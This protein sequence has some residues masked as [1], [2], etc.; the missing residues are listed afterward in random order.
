[1]T[2]P[3]IENEVILA[4]AGTGKTHALTSRILRLLALEVRPD[5]L[6]ALTFTRKAAGEFAN[7]VFRRLARAAREPDAAAQLAAD[8]ELDGWTPAR[9]A[10]LLARIVH[11]MERLQFRTFD[12]F[13]QRVVS[14]MPFELGLPGGVQML[15]ESEA[16]ELRDR[17][18]TRLLA[19]DHDPAAQDALLAAYR[20]ATWGA[21]EKGLRRK[22]E[23]FI[24]TSHAHFLESREACQWGDIAGIWPDGC[25]WLEESEDIREDALTLE[26]WAREK[27]GEVYRS[28]EKFAVEAAK[29]EPGMRLPTGR[30]GE[31]ILE[32]FAADPRS[33]AL[34]LT[35]RRKEVLIDE[36]M[37]LPL[38]RIVGRLV[39]GSLRRHLRV[40]TGI[41]RVLEPFD[42][43]YHE[44][45]RL[46]GR[47][48]FA[49][50]VE[51]LRRVPALEWQARL[52]ARVDHWLFDEFQDTSLQQWQVVEN[53]VDEV[54]QDASGRR[55]AFFVGDP[56]Q[57]IYRWRGGEHRLLERI[58]AHYGGRFRER[59]LVKS[60]RSDP[61]VIELVNRYGAVAADPANGL[62]AEVVAEWQRFWLAHESAA[63][64]RQGHA[65]MQLLENE[66][67]LPDRVLAALE[68]IDPIGRGLS[69]A[70]LTRN[71]TAARELA[72]G[73]RER[74]FLRVAAETDEQIAID[75]PV[76]RGLLALIAAVTHPADSASR[77]AVA[78]SPLGALL[79]E[80]GWSALA[81]W[82]F[83]RVTAAGL[84]ATL[85]AVI[86]RLPQGAPTD[87]FSRQRLRL[88]FEL[89][90]TH[91]ATGRDGLDGFLRLAASH[92]R[93]ETASSGNVQILTIHR[94]KGLGF[95]VV[96]LPVFDT[97]RMDGAPTDAFLAWR[98][99]RLATEWLL[100]RPTSVVAGM[101]AV[102]A[103]AHEQQRRDAA[104]DELCVWYVGLTRARHALHVFTL[105]PGK[106]GGTSPVVLLHRA[107][108]SVESAPEGLLWTAGDADWFRAI[109]D[110]K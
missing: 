100:H 94:S 11:E 19:A 103:R 101:D 66:E 13:F 5:A 31:Q 9:F 108:A 104:Y 41:R 99:E 105:A 29:W 55:S 93:R 37:V 109:G 67:E 53:L 102:L 79:D 96:I 1:M 34:T 16:A 4:S 64:E 25:A 44:E 46:S 110:Q 18:L 60:Y 62:P 7:T 106:S 39:C 95:D 22:L 14:A 20:E 77:H 54:V 87:A 71:N 50:V 30:V 80:G 90:R 63:P 49:D 58:L 82:F 23:G 92:A 74:G 32:Q 56:K 51:M 84:E 3:L 12:A 91:D 28:L 69:C 21:E 45:V 35:Y 97:T 98:G 86:D 6:L 89:A 47:L 59:A 10:A 85:R 27:D 78:M 81:D 52:D 107:V 72:A 65:T 70:V 68:R 43:A 42:A 2:V 17:V 33:T 88:L 24:E 48:S 73:L 26:H 76:N 75:A 38:R 57:S 61:A 15:S 40:T 8:L 83:A 36:S